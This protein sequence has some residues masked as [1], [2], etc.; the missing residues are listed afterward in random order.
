MRTIEDVINHLYSCPET[1][2][3]SVGGNIKDAGVANLAIAILHLHQLKRLWI[4]GWFTDYGAVAMSWALAEHPGSSRISLEGDFGP[5]GLI[6]ILNA[7]KKHHSLTDLEL[8]ADSSVKNAPYIDSKQC[9]RILSQLPKLE[10][11]RLQGR[12]TSLSDF[13]TLP[14]RIV[15]LMV[16][17]RSFRG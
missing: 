15:S 11:L 4:K 9:V 6:S 2:S 13:E 5:V 1:N 17:G 10:A 12:F 8:I 16:N 7:I 3:V 14:R